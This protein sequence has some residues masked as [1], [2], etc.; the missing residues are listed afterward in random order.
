MERLLWFIFIRWSWNVAIGCV[1]SF[2]YAE[3][4]A[5]TVEKGD[6]GCVAQWHTS[7]VKRTV[8]QRLC[9]TVYI[10]N[11]R[12]GDACL[13]LEK[14][15][16]QTVLC[17]TKTPLF[18]RAHILLQTWGE[19]LHCLCIRSSCGVQ[20]EWGMQ[21]VHTHSPDFQLLV[22]GQHSSIKLELLP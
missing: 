4:P 15:A 6:V 12:M 21:E 16:L 20:Q 13:H 8:C 9:T 22:S 18:L 2:M 3:P 11:W 1:I 10:L 7:H 5:H 19:I 14:D 17:T